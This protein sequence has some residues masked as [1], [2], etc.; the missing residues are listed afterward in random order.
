VPTHARVSPPL[1][2]F[3]APLIIFLPPPRVLQ[4][5][6]GLVQ[7]RRLLGEPVGLLRV[8]IRMEHTDAADPFVPDLLRSC[9]GRDPENGVIVVAPRTVHAREKEGG[10]GCNLL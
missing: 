6:V 7:A 3:T 8:T 10:S 5:V 9:R 4:R 2:V 1:R